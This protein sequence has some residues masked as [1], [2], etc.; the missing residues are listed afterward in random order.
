M[1]HALVLTAA[2]GSSRMGDAGK[3]EYLTVSETPGCRISV[4]SS[5]LYAFLETRLFS[6]VMITVPSGGEEKA[7]AVLAEDA[8]I[9]PLLDETGCRLAFTEGGASRQDSVRRGLESIAIGASADKRTPTTV[10]IHDAARPWITAELV[11]TVL[12]AVLA[13]GAAVPAIPTVDTQKETDD[14]GRIVRHLD[15]SRVMAVQT[16]QGFRFTELL[17]AHMKA[18]NDGHHYTD[19]TEIWGK[20]AGDV[21]V[22]PGDRENRKVTFKEDLS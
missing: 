13:H 7:R 2:G 3:K 4:L 15:R 20:Y 5:S 18:S 8:R 10:L 11:R 19:D 9:K 22:C 16:P 14:K 17:D 6:I 21:Y 1:T 12:S